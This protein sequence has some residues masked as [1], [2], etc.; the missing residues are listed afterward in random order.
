M[1]LTHD[2]HLKEKGALSHAPPCFL[3]DIGSIGSPRFRACEAGSIKYLSNYLS[4]FHFPFFFLL[5]GF[6]SVPACSAP[7]CSAP[8]T[9]LVSPE[10]AAAPTFCTASESSFVLASRSSLDPLSR[11][12][13][14][15]LTFPQPQFYPP[16]LL[17]HL[18]P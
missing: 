18:R 12:S 13:L 3:F 15:A 10:Y 14:S 7:A 1:I 6:F 2:E 11:I 16:V 8:G 17:C 9:P 4:L 5:F